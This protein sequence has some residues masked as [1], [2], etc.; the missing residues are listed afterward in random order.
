MKN[1]L[2]VR[3]SQHTRENTGSSVKFSYYSGSRKSAEKVGNVP[4]DGV[5]RARRQRSRPIGVLL[6]ILLFI[7]AVFA[8]PVKYSPKI[9]NS[10][11]GSARLS[12]AQMN[13]ISSYSKELMGSSVFNRTKLSFQS[14]VITSKLVQK[15]PAVRAV[16][17]HFSFFGG[18]PRFVIYPKDPSLIVQ[19]GADS[20][21]AVDASGI[22]FEQVDLANA[23][24]AGLPI[25]K[26]GNVDSVSIGQQLVP[27]GYVSFVSSLDYQISHSGISIVSLDLVAGG[28]ELDATISGHKYKVKFNVLGNAR[29]QAGEYLAARSYL[30][31]HRI[32]PGKYLDVRVEGKTY[33]K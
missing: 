24:S 6:V 25:L 31:K 2:R 29:Q 11:Q 19:E 12:A 14:S 10:A 16:D 32:T 18:E 13:E 21:Y 20:Y 1:K 9:V 27:S 3:K 4:K 30:T 28:E 17:I 26:I 22:P 7:V 5:I 15:F 33:F 23:T 8:L